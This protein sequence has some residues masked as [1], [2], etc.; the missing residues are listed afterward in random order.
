M[1]A[2]LPLPLRR[3]LVRRGLAGAAVAMATLMV[4]AAPSEA[5]AVIRDVEIETTLRGYVDPIFVAAGLD[6]SQIEV[7]LLQDN[8]INAFVTNSRTMFIH[9]GLIT[10]VESPNELKGIMA[11]ETGHMAG[12]HVL[13]S[14]EAMSQA[15]VPAMLSVGIGILAIAAGAPSAGAALIAGSQQ[16]AMADFVQFSQAQES[17]ADQA[18]VTFMDAAG[19]S[20]EG[21]VSFASR[22]FRYNEMRSAQRVPPWMRT[23]PL[24]TDRI[25]ALRQRVSQSEHLTAH[26]APAEMEHL[27]L[28]QAK[29]FGYTENAARTYQKYPETDQSAAGRYAR[30]V[31]AMRSSDFSK[32]DKEAESLTREFPNNPYY[33][34]LVGEILLTSG[35]VAE[36]V[37][38]H[39]R[40]LDLRPG[41]ALLQINLARALLATNQKPATDEAIGFLQAATRTEPDNTSAWYELAS[42]YDTRGEEGLARLASAELRYSIG[43][44]PAARSFAERAKERLDQGTVSYQRALDISTL[45]ETRVRDGRRG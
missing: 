5:R 8:S 2:V 1:P 44:W 16:F 21:L 23:H 27:K 15:M 43:D 36:S 41:S 22:Q 31:A 6:P 38:H 7:V 24:W 42:A 29:L 32:A 25:Q 14:R 18:A 12:G 20:G 10:A 39:R 17:Q 28:I 34:E 40:A 11:H 35:R 3:G 30:S 45:S 13:R 19:Q 33:H 4:F 37:P 26:D 9:T